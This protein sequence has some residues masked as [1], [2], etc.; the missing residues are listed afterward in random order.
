MLSPPADRPTPSPADLQ[1]LLDVSLTALALWRPRYSPNGADVT[2]F[3]CAYLNPAAQQFLGQAQRPEESFLVLFPNAR[4]NGLLA[5][6]CRVMETGEPDH[7]EVRYTADDLDHSFRVAARRQGAQLAASFTDITRVPCA[8]VETALRESQAAETV[9]RADAERQRAT[10]ARYLGRTHAA[11]CVLRGPAHAFEYSNP[12][13]ERL[14]SGRLLPLGSPLAAVFPAALAQAVVPALDG[15]YATGDSFFGVEQALTLTVGDGPA[16]R[17]YFTFSFDAYE[18]H[19]RTAGVSIFAYNVTEEVLA[20]Q[21]AEALQAEVLEAARQQL[22][23]RNTFHE[24]FEQTPALVALMRQP[25]HRFDYVNAAYQ[26]LFPGRPLVGHDLAVA[27]PEAQAQGVI[28]L[29]DRVY[30]TG[31]TYFGAELP[32]QV[33]PA[34]GQPAR[35]EYYNFTYQAFREAGQVAGISIFGFHVT[36]QVRARQQQQ[37]ANQALTESNRQL[38][39]SNND[40]DTFI[41]TASHDLKTPITNLEGLLHALCEELPA[42][43]RQAPDVAPLLDRMQHAV[44]R[45]KLTIAQLTDLTKLQRADAQPAETVDLAT[46]VDDIRLDLT[47]QLSAS[48]AQLTVDVASCPRVSFAPKNLRSIVYNLLS[49][50]VKYRDPDRAPR[51]RLRCRSEENGPVVLDVQDNG[52]GLT[53]DQQGK[54]FG[55]F[56]RLHDH[57]E[58]AGIGLYMVKRI[59]ENAGGTIAVQSTP[60]VGT[61]FTITLPAPAVAHMTPAL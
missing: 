50:A 16:A 55:L 57:V 45:F 6:C 31:E 9:A 3:T 51:V 53:D 60:G 23:E 56:R 43:L 2:D 44:D 15:V 42:A 33:A 14:F 25:G 58:G 36:P 39:R 4:E 10:L 20:R 35:L 48:T 26:A 12:T 27:V 54:L 30:R 28:D 8:A 52:L 22:N 37:D 34:D 24:V 13:F 38:M 40:L 11:I 18:E 5:F 29:L 21:H 19:G 7:F 47:Q 1:A 41:Y 46:L 17:C 49:N 32:F 59:V 61:T